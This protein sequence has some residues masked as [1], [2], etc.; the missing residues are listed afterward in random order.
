MLTILVMCLSSQA[1]EDGIQCRPIEVYASKHA[2]RA[3]EREL[4][5]RNHLKAVDWYCVKG[6]GTLASN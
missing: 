6:P 2:C 5:K 3:M 1:F 4:T